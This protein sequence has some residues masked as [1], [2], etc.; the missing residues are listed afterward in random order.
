MGAYVFCKGFIGTMTEVQAAEIDSY[1]QGNAFF[2]SA[3]HGLQ[4]IPAKM[5]RM[6]VGGGNDDSAI[7]R[8]QLPV[9]AR[10]SGPRRASASA[11]RFAKHRAHPCCFRLLGNGIFK[12]TYRQT[13]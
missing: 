11:H 8:W 2:Q 4:G 3:H 10:N 9:L 5:G 1:C 13:W 6:G 7:I 12:N